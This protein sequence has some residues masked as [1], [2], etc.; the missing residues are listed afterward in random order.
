MTHQDEGH[1][2]RGLEWSGVQGLLSPCSRG[3][4]LSPSWRRSSEGS[5]EGHELRGCGRW[6]PGTWPWQ[7]HGD[8]LRLTGSEC[9][10]GPEHKS[11]RSQTRWARL[12]PPPPAPPPVTVTAHDVPPSF[13]SLGISPVQ[14][15]CPADWG[16]STYQASLGHR[17]RDGRT[18]PQR[19][20]PMQTL[21]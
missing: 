11:S 12:L 7:A 14:H 4:P 2:G 10:L 21:P 3:V 19:A 20:R 15:A 13:L 8:M 5:Q 1:R 6:A 17:C 16:T 18:D 9:R